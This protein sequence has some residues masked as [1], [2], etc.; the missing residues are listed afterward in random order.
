[1]TSVMAVDSVV[2]L[3]V[4]EAHR[5]RRPP[6]TTSVPSSGSNNSRTK[7]LPLTGVGAASGQQQQLIR[8]SSDGTAV[9]PSSPTNADVVV[10]SHHSTQRLHFLTHCGTVWVGCLRDQVRHCWTM[11]TKRKKEEDLDDVMFGKTTRHRPEELKSLERS[12]KFTRKEIQLIYRGFKQECP[13]GVVDEQSFKEIFVQFFPQGD[14]SQYAHYVFKTFKNGGTGTIKFE[15]FLQSLSQASRGT[16]QEK[17]RWIFGLYDLNGD[18][19]IS[20]S[21]MTSVAM[22]IFDMLGRHAAPAV[23]DQTASKHIDQIF[24]KIDVNHDGLITFEELSQ[25]C[26]RE[27]RFVKSL[28][29]LDTVL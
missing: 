23:D 10:S 16:I 21:E 29:M 6:G 2:V 19:Y 8:N 11:F 22:A 26:T 3:R 7:L 9:P 17:L 12:T 4:G 14:A 25:W 15:D 1:M 24:H 20:K 5:C 27:E 13:N 18:G 28:G